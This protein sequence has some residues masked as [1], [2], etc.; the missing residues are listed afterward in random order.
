[1]RKLLT[2]L[3]ALAVTVGVSLVLLLWSAAS[4][5]QMPMTGAGLAK[6]AAGGGA[7]VT[8]DALGSVG[9]ITFGANSATYGGLTTTASANLILVFVNMR[10]GGSSDLTSVVWDAAGANQ[11]MTRI[12]EEPENAGTAASLIVY[13]L[14]APAS[15]GAKLITLT[16]TNGAFVYSGGAAS[17]RGANSVLASA[18]PVG[19]IAKGN[20]AGSNVPSWNTATSSDTFTVA[21]GHM[22]FLA[23][24]MST[25]N[26]S[27]VSWTPSA[28]ASD[29]GGRVGYLSS[30]SGT[31]SFK[32]TGDVSDLAAG[33]GLDISP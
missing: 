1:M 11:A 15:F 12:S 26:T 3:I 10:S 24:K 25:N 17:Y 28:S 30:T 29:S 4:W 32:I 16:M 33:I 2:F 27:F 19:S 22:S 6:P 23:N 20:S 18:V 31:V 8:Q 7:S 14:V 9:V 21:A 5:A 13:G